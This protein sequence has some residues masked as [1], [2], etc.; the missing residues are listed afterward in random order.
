MI[1]NAAKYWNSKKPAIIQ[2]KDKT[3][4][5]IAIAQIYKTSLLNES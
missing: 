4:T 2:T 5:Q 1:K 3:A